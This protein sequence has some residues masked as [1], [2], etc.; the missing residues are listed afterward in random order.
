MN[1]IIS[2]NRLEQ[3][4][5]NFNHESKT[6]SLISEIQNIYLEHT[7][8]HWKNSWE[9][10]GNRES[11]ELEVQHPIIG[12]NLFL[13]ICDDESLKLRG[14]NDFELL[15]NATS[16]S[17]RFD[18]NYDMFK[19][20]IFYYYY[21]NSNSWNSNRLFII[22]LCKI[23]YETSCTQRELFKEIPTD[24]YGDSDPILSPRFHRNEQL[25]KILK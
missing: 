17:V 25:K 21:T 13:L 15:I 12:H 18:I 11:E 9:N 19:I 2:I 6:K 7:T 24:I 5:M 20:D 22:N 14:P 16:D 1:S 4:L 8:H 23:F 10:E 3:K